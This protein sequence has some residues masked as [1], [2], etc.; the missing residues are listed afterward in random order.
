VDIE[1]IHTRLA[2]IALLVPGVST[3]YA[4]Q[5]RNVAPSDFPT[6]ITL[7]GSGSFD[8][9][10]DGTSD[11]LVET[12][13][14]RQLL[15]VKPWVQGEELESEDAV[16]PYFDRFIQNFLGRPGLELI[17][18]GESLPLVQNTRMTGDSGVINL[19]LAGIAYVGV[20][21]TIDVLFY[22]P[23]SHVG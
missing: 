10:G 18:G 16:K 19:V 4:G 9:G 5:P 13:T 7:I 22:R 8:Y 11:F 6:V 23:I 12:R 2:D 21:F 20:E 3:S 1:T 14:F 15:L 17:R